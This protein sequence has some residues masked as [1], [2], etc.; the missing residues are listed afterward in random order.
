M[1]AP[2]LALGGTMTWTL[3]DDAALPALLLMTGKRK[4]AGKN[5]RIPKPANH[6]SRPCN[7]VGRRRCGHSQ[8]VSAFASTA[9][10]DMEE[11]Y[12]HQVVAFLLYAEVERHSVL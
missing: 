7:H 11:S 6:G 9:P 5:K 12:L 3:A 2:A 4:S 10:L 8:C 1:A